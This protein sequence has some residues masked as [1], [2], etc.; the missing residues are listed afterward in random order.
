MSY[1]FGSPNEGTRKPLRKGGKTKKRSH[2]PRAGRR[3]GGSGYVPTNGTTGTSLIGTGKTDTENFLRPTTAMKGGKLTS[4]YNVLIENLYSLNNSKFFAGFIMLIVNIGSKHITID[5]SNSQE[6][7]IKYTLGRQI[8]VFAILWMATRDIVVALILSC[9][10]ILFADYLFNENS[11]YCMFAGHGTELKD[12]IDADGDG[13]IS[14]KEI[15]DAISI[16]KKA[17]D[18]KIEQN[19]KSGAEDKDVKNT[20]VRENFM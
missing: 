17:H 20:L 14:E 13:K 18:K 9:V 15:Q 12:V 2:Y 6:S 1:F 11:K 7:Y 10:F 8:L 16:L 4:F 5:L 19:K 3:V